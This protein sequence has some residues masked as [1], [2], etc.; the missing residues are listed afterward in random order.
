MAGGFV[1]AYIVMATELIG[2][3]IVFPCFLVGHQDGG[4][5]GAVYFKDT[6]QHFEVHYCLN[7]KWGYV[8]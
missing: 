5:V 2:K 1:G 7:C 4:Y 8:L 6:D 3:R